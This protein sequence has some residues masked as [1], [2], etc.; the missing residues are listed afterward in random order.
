MMSSSVGLFLADDRVL[1]RVIRGCLLDSCLNETIL[2]FLEILCS[3]ESRDDPLSRFFPEELLEAGF[4]FETPC[5]LA[6]LPFK[7]L[8][9]SSLLVLILVSTS[10]SFFFA[11]TR[12]LFF[13]FLSDV[14]GLWALIEFLSLSLSTTFPRDF[15]GTSSFLRRPSKYAKIHRGFEGLLVEA[16]R[17]SLPVNTPLSCTISTRSP[18]LYVVCLRLCERRREREFMIQKYKEILCF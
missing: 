7:L 4:V 1:T 8:S 11:S 18:F 14:S 17:R 16:L 3:C 10:S 2:A 13:F 15:S 12:P 6:A 9:P 5:A